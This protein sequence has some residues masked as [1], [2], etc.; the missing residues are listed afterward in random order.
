M[1]PL[2]LSSITK[3]FGT[4]VVIHGLDLTVQEGEAI[5]LLGPSGCGKTTCLRMIAGFE[6]PDSGTIEFGTRVLVG[7]GT[8]VE[9]QHRNMSVVFQN[10]ALWP[11]MTVG[12]NV[13]Y[14][15][16]TARMKKAKIRQRVA[17]ALEMVQL[18]GLRDRYIH[19][20]SGGQ[21]QRVALARALVNEPELLLLDEPLSNLDT[22]LRE[23]MRA[24]VKQIQ[25]SLGLAM[26]Y[27]TH[28][29]AEALSLADRLVVMNKGRIEQIGMPED[30][31][32]HPAT[33]YVAQALGPTNIAQ[34]SVR[35]L[36]GDRSTGNICIAGSDQ[37]VLIPNGR[38]LTT[39][40]RVAVSIR[41]NSIDLVEHRTEP[42]QIEGTIV[43]AMFFGDHVQYRVDVAGWSDSLRVT[44]NHGRP[45]DLG[46]KA[47]LEIEPLRFTILA[48][49]PGV[50][51]TSQLQEANAVGPEDYT[52]TGM[53]QATPKTGEG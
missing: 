43:E 21:Q 36:S 1:N 29:P 14:G 53:A 47:F 16:T 46:S 41:P 10:Y 13:A 12:Q 5:V 42:N 6:R 51:R 26:I 18:G 9:P 35:A 20:L 34:A 7:E 45:L 50:N 23:D 15:P 32:N 49:A 37:P 8:Y 4:N 52:Q 25:R 38:S 40:D 19:Q 3:A 22:R 11:H 44:A 48:D 17:D 2:I 28:D 33:S 31:Y 24:E 39:G 30:I 27:V